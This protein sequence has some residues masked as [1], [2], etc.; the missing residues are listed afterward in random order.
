MA[1]AA[2]EED[3]KDRESHFEGGVAFCFQH[4]A[5][6]VVGEENIEVVGSVGRE[7]VGVEGGGGRLLLSGRED[8]LEVLA[9]GD[10]D[11]EKKSL[12]RRWPCNGGKRF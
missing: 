10:A 11:G 8:G 4:A 2:V 12:R 3:P 9:A 5:Y 6:A 7:E 1:A